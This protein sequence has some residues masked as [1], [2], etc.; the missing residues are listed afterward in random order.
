LSLS[1]GKGDDDPPDMRRL[2]AH[3]SICAGI[4]RNL[5]CF[6]LWL[7]RRPNRIGRA[8]ES[9]RDDRGASRQTLR[10][11]GHRHFAF[12]RE[13]RHRADK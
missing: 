1:L 12:N 8:D 4:R 11:S 9:K 2:G 5:C 7:R 6:S 10:L 3:L 13:K